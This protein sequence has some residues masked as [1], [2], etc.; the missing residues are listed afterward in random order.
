M[1]K[2]K[3]QKDVF[4]YILAE[5]TAY[6]TRGVPVLSNWDFFMKE[7]IERSVALKNSKFWKGENDG[8]RPNKNIILPILNVAYRTEGFDV[9][10][11]EAYVNDLKNHYKSFI[12]RKYHT[13]WARKY[14]IDTF[15]DETVEGYVDFGL[16]VSKN[17]NDK[18]PENVNLQQ[19]A[20]CDQTDI[21]SGPICLEHS[22]SIDQ[23]LDF[24]G[25]W[26]DDEIDRAILQAESAKTV[27]NANN[28]KAE[29]PG[30]YIKVYELH[31]VLPEK[32][33][34][35]KEG[36][37]YSTS[38][39]YVRQLQ[40]ITFYKDKDGNKQGICLFKGK[41]S[42]PVFKAI[43]RTNR[44]G[45]ACG[46]GGIEELF[47]AQTWT[48]YSEIQ[49]KKM[50][51]AAAIMILKT[52]DKKFAQ[53][54][55]VSD[56]MKNE[57]AVL[58]EGTDLTQVSITPQNKAMFDAYVNQWEQTGR[59]IGSASDPQLGL[60][61]VSGTPLGTTQIVT[62]QGIGIHDYRQGQ[63]ATYFG[64]LYRDW[65]LHWLV[66]DINRGDEWI[67]E[68][69]IEE[70]K[71]VADK[72]AVKSTNKRLKELMLSRKSV[73]PEQQAQLTQ[74]IKDSFMKGGKKKFIK[75][76]KDEFANI[77]ID[78]EI[79]IAGKQKNLADVV[80][81]LNGVFRT[82]F[83]NPQ[84]LQYEPMGK[85]FNQIIESSGFSPMDF[86]GFTEA[87]EQVEEQPQPGAVPSTMQ[88]NLQANNQ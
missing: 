40:I 8:N 88:P 59:T 85:L 13:R 48:N 51:D 39:K 71:D 87:P 50:L 72:V 2:E 15:I 22:Y 4:A 42:R 31:G 44:F 55:K 19:I 46:M 25:K 60:N 34:S 52:T 27:S 30:K 57:I 68:L 33:L 6:E 43:K 62:S 7:H 78:V 11:I 3:E 74:F 49:L 47:E 5:K 9:K 21:L 26:I 36:D 65:I 28:N 14:S 61:P 37:E 29:T 79:N 54:N 32:W 10:H 23:L 63:L 82:V 64:E 41:E 45:T 1:E 70:L 77:P 84:V 83:M 80:N 86:S 20:F 81:K 18:R 12:V 75:A 53:N 56:L 16:A 66:A 17:V 58:E 76:I 69:S 35:K 67:D 24:K 73:T 38:N